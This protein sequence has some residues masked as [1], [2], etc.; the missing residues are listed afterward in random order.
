MAYR[1]PEYNIDNFPAFVAHH[2]N[3]DIYINHRGHSAAIPTPEAAAN[4][5]KASHF[6]DFHY[7]RMALRNIAHAT[8]ADAASALANV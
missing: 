2:G 6:G 8:L 4:G 1:H 5:C 7:T 3:W